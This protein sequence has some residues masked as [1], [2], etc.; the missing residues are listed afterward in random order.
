[1][2]LLRLKLHMLHIEFFRQL[3]T[4][5]V[6]DGIILLSSLVTLEDEYGATKILFIGP[7]EGGLKVE[8]DGSEIVV[9]TPASPMGRGLLGRRAGDTAEIET[10]TSRKEYAIVEVA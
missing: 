7:T 5:G 1:M 2:T 6:K 10:G 3:N 8:Q 4:G 9:I